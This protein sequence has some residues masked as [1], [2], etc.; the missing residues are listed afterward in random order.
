[1]NLP[2][3]EGQ[4]PVMVTGAQQTDRKEEN[5]SVS[6]LGQ[7]LVDGKEVVFVI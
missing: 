5:P 3:K 7:Q 4:P 6:T 2:G 1:M